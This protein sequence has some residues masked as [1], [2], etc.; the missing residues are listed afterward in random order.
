MGLVGLARHRPR[1]RRRGMVKPWAGR[2][3]LPLDGEHPVP[4]EIPEGPVVGEH[5]EA[6]AGALEGPARA[7]AAVETVAGVLAHDVEPL[8]R[9]TC[10]ATRS[11]MPLLGQVGVGVEHGGHHLDLAVGI[12]VDQGHLGVVDRTRLRCA[13]GRLAGPKR[14]SARSCMAWRF[15][16]R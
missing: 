2:E 5:V 7:V 16:S 4:L 1:P 9:P 3:V 11:S 12:P 8:A 10:C 13:R 14:P 6:V 15:F